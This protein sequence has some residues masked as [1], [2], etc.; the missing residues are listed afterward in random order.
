MSQAFGH[1][2]LTVPEQ[3]I[4]K[5][6][7]KD[8]GYLTLE[9]V[10][11][12]LEC[13]KDQAAGELRN[14]MEFDYVERDPENGFHL[15]EDDEDDSES[16]E[17]GEAA[18]KTFMEEL[19][20]SADDDAGEAVE[21]RDD[22]PEDVADE[23]YVY[24]SLSSVNTNGQTNAYHDTGD[25]HYLNN[26]E[27]EVKPLNYLRSQGF[28]E[29]KACS[30]CNPPSLNGEPEQP[31]EEEQ[32]DEQQREEIDGETDE[33]EQP[34]SGSGLLKH[35]PDGFEDAPHE[36]QLMWIEER[37]TAVEVA[38]SLRGLHGRPERD[39]EDLRKKDQV[40]IL[41]GILGY[42]EQRGDA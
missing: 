42:T 32:K 30:A 3:R 37:M 4:V 15:P 16:F 5:K 40:A 41:L 31:T 14:L 38:N 21:A 6:L 22:V 25:C 9:D 29:W 17:N 27:V 10:A 20:D 36:M 39:T 7:R 35:L 2:E 23:D 24:V 28:G 11:E 18:A 8:G 33:T 13:T 26:A 19:S 34:S 1:E 12:L